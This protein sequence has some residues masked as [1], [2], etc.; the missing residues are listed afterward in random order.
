MADFE[1]ILKKIILQLDEINR[2]IAE[3]NEA[4]R[5]ALQ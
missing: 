4:L 2:Q 3:I 1:I 5:E